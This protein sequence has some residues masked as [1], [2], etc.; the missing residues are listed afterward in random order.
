MSVDTKARGNLRTRVLH[1]LVS[2]GNDGLT[3]CEL[4][5][6]LCANKNHVPCR[7]RDVELNGLCQKTSKRRDTD[8]GTSAI[9]HVATP[10]GIGY[11]QTG[12]T[13][14]GRPTPGGDQTVPRVVTIQHK[15]GGRVIRELKAQA[16][17][18]GRVT[19]IRF[20]EAMT[21]LS[22]DEVSIR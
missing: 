2:V 22:G 21:C 8:T 18:R 6:I 17:T 10:L 20:P 11:A 9:V 1:A 19:S 5:S 7:R 4:A 13:V 14:P 3:D 16:K 12:K 15:R